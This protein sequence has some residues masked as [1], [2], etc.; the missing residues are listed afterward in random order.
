MDYPTG[1]EERQFG[2][3]V[4]FV[5]ERTILLVVGGSEQGAGSTSSTTDESFCGVKAGMPNEEHLKSAAKWMKSRTESSSSCIH[6]GAWLREPMGSFLSIH[7]HA[8]MRRHGTLE[9]T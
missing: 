6:A 1:R 4:V 9:T 2:V 5:S 7:R 3:S 8:R